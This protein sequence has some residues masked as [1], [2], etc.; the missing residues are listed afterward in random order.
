V[1]LEHDAYVSDIKFVN[2]E[3]VYVS[4]GDKAIHLWDVES[5]QSKHVFKH[6]TG[7][8]S[9]IELLDQSGEGNVLISGSIDKTIKIWDRRVSNAAPLV[10]LPGHSGFVNCLASMP[11]KDGNNMRNTFASGSDDGTCRL[12]DMRAM[13]QLSIFASASSQGDGQGLNS[14]SFSKSGRLLF[15]AYASPVCYIWDTIFGEALDEL[16]DHKEDVSCV[17]TSPDGKAVATC[18]WDGTVGLWA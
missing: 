18:S 7:D 17:S 10:T 4:S 3:E 9:C 12:W 16:N 8:V 5:G 1:R 13:K 15:T 2:D 6:H 14:I 11:G